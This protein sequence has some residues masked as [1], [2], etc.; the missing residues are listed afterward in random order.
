VAGGFATW[1]LPLRNK[2]GYL[3]LLSENCILYFLNYFN[4]F[5]QAALLKCDTILHG[6]KINVTYATDKASVV[7]K[8]SETE[9]SQISSNKKPKKSGSKW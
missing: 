6:R 3:L 7:A 5:L 2:Q 1:N 8:V 9:I 4:I